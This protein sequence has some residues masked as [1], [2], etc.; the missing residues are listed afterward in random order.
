MKKTLEIIIIMIIIM[1]IIMVYSIRL[2]FGIFNYFAFILEI[3]FYLIKI[4]VQII[5][6]Y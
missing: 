5:L 1:L 3:I 2:L 6:K 4:K